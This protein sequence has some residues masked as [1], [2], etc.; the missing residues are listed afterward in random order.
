MRFQYKFLQVIE[1]MH[2]YIDESGNF[3]IPP[4]SRSKISCVAA[5][6]IPSASHEEILKEFL[7]IRSSWGSIQ[8]EIKGSS[9]NETQMAEVL[10]LLQKYEVLVDFC[11]I[12]MGLHTEQQV[13]DFQHT[14]ADELIKHLTPT[15]QPTLVKELHLARQYALNMPSQ[16]FVQA[17]TLINLIDRLMET[18]IMYY[19]Q[20][21][22]EEIG[23]FHW[24]IDAKD[25]GITKFEEWW[26]SLI[27]PVIETKSLNK[28]MLIL[29]TGNYSYFDRFSRTL[30]NIPDHWK[31]DI[32]SQNTPIKAPELKAIM[33]E[34]LVFE[35]SKN[36]LG[37]QLV[38]FV[39]SAFTRAMNNTLQIEG[40]EKLGSLLIK[41]ARLTIDLIQLRGGVT[42][43][44][45]H[46]FYRNV[47]LQLESKAKSML[48]R[49]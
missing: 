28:P 35:S 8:D 40:W 20:R 2:I 45:T 13:K 26:K 42:N 29:K 1:C 10:S 22:P 31:D 32:G 18:A 23:S 24:V 19:C 17:I 30:V 37:L 5:L 11:A 3:I 6:V 33:L 7:Y 15:H 12:D 14:Q 16:L 9:L 34:S 39:A 43:T 49:P 46:S 38:D 21:L 44:P 4:N 27:C 25:I 41:R 48:L 36:Y 47:I